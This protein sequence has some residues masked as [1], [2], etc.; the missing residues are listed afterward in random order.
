VKFTVW[1]RGRGK[2]SCTVFGS[3]YKRSVHENETPSHYL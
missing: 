2:R 3:F 1:T